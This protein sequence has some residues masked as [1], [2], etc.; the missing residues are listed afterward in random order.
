M[1]GITLPTRRAPSAL[2]AM[3]ALVLVGACAAL[4]GAAGQTCTVS[5]SSVTLSSGSC[6]ITPNTTLN[7]SPAVHATN[8]AQITTNNVTVNPFNG[9][10]VGGLAE[11]LGTIIFSP[12]SSINGNWATAASA[13]TGGQIIFEGG[14]A[15]NPP[16][17]GGSTAL[18]ANGV[19]AGGQASQIIATGLTVNLNGGGGN[20]AA[21]A[22]AGG[23]IVLND[24]TTIS[25]APGGGG[26]TGLLA[27][28]AGSQIVTNGAILTMPGGGGGDTGVRADTGATV[29]LNQGSVTVQSNG[30]GEIGLLASGAGSSIN[31]TDVIVSVSNSG[32]GRGGFLQNGASINFSGGSL[33]TSGPGTYGFLFQAPSGVLNALTV[34][35]AQ[36]SSAAD[37]FAVQGGLANIAVTDSTV[38]GNNGILLSASQNAGAP[39]VVTMIANS[40]MLTGAI[41]T[42][43]ASTSTVT[44][45]SGTTWLMT[46]NSNVTNLTNNESSIFFT[47]PT[48]DPT[49]LGSYKTLTATNYA[50]MGG[51]ILLN[52]YLGGD[53]SPSDRLIING[54]T[55]TGATSLMFHNTTGPGAQTAANGI[56]VVNAISGGTTV[57]GAFVLNGEARG[58]DFDYQLFR[59]GLGGTNPNDWFLRSTFIV[60]PEP[61][62]PIPPEP[63]PL[64]PDP[65]PNPLPPGVYPIIGPE[66]ATYGIVQP[67]ARQLGLDTLGTLHERIG[68]TLTQDNAG[69]SGT[70]WGR[71]DWARF[72]GQQVNNRYQAFADPRADG[73]LGGFQGGL[74]LW[75]GSF[76]P[77][78]RDA[79]GVYLA[80]GHADIQV[81][82][83]VTNTPATAYVLTHTG[84]VNLDAYS[85]AAYW[86]HYGPTG[87]YVDAVLQGT[88]YGGSAMTQF[89]QL[90][91]NGYGFISSL[92]TGYP[93][94][95]PLGPRFVLEPQAQ[96]IWQQVTLNQA[97]DGEGPVAL[98][99]TSGPTGRI[100]VRG[101]WTIVGENGQI[102]QPYARAN[103]WRD[104]GAE[105]TTTFG[106][107]AVP[108]IEEATR[109]ELAGGLTAK[110]NDR[111]SLYAQAGYQFAVAQTNDTTRNGVKGDVG[112]RYAW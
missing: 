79:A 108:L 49:Q 107:D 48:G 3:A 66:L 7:G 19:G 42:D 109:L 73:W 5:G 54:G 34:T 84:T 10:S 82:G 87:W 25:F 51:E 16:F 102:W 83:L 36:I 55:A 46:G 53:G 39:A 99:S 15:I 26:N 96:I 94:P 43:S 52:T 37:A 80:Y 111:L 77:G 60:P 93:V 29:N 38:I 90:P 86:T 56:L 31:A 106:V 63:G 71:A 74:D 17:G 24:G 98:G 103:L 75:R 11:T 21:R 59:G 78:H 68:D 70:G 8:S 112:L 95:L 104:W 88:R 35:G 20:V 6:A 47:P 50:G 22:G 30:G 41:V 92:E 76:L 110:L 67:I 2:R 27:T 32:S 1:L 65:P 105:A 18:L 72:F 4:D 101:Q 91:T 58:G 23:S 13:Q 33:T 89:A 64:P 14:T 69:G 45:G 97:N 81:N 85:A 57:P 28:G 9:G 40:S 61:P 100:G 62:E 44:L 12:G